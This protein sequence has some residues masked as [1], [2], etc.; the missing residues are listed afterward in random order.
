M[1]K[2]LCNHCEKFFLGSPRHK[3]QMHCNKAG[4]QKARR[5]AWQRNKKRTDS[6]YRLNQKQCNKNWAKANPDY[7]KKYR[8]KN[9]KKAER[10]RI[11]QTIRNRRSKENSL[12]RKMDMTSIAKMD[13]LT[14]IHSKISGQFWMVPVIAKMDPLKVNIHT[15]SSAYE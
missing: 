15:I 13:P 12:N 2:I 11:L 3:N 1:V 6:D 9:P 7:W 5:A 4:C 14:S 8:K 10:N